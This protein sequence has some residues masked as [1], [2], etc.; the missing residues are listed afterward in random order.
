METRQILITKEEAQKLIGQD[1]TMDSIIYRTFPEL[2]V[3]SLPKKWE[4]LKEISGFFV[5]IFSDIESNGQDKVCYENKNIFYTKKQARSALAMA[6]LSQLMAAYNGDWVADW[7][8]FEQKKYIIERVKNKIN[9]NGTTFYYTFLSF[10][11]SE[12][13]DEFL[14]NFEP[15]I[16]EYFEL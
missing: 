14:K 12:L 6:Q 2:K 5:D 10:K 3:K 15:L 9:K 13:R 16:K 7:G 4:D 11:T 8:D 1:E